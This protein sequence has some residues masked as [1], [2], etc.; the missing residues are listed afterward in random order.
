M[1]GQSR[2]SHAVSVFVSSMASRLI[3]EEYRS[4]CFLLSVVN[5]YCSYRVI[6]SSIFKQFELERPMH[7]PHAIDLTVVC[8]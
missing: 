3:E 5:M 8:L 1:S 6:N 4:D 2:S 7:L